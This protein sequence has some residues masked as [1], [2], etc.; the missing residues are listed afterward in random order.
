MLFLDLDADTCAHL[1]IALRAHKMSLARHGQS[2]PAG[3]T[4]LEEY[5]T[6]LVK[7]RQGASAATVSDTRMHDLREREFLTR[8]QASFIASVSVSTVD[9]WTASGR[10]PSRRIG[11]LRRIARADLDAC[12]GGNGVAA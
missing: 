10:L 11:G 4:E 5:V 1:A 9:R 6:E 2:E 8:E 7:R 12:L 3:F